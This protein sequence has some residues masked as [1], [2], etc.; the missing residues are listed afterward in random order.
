M[1]ETKT[2]GYDNC[3]VAFERG[4]IYTVKMDG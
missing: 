3:K 1:G 4:L 2:V